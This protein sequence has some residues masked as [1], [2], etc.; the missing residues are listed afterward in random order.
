MDNAIGFSNTYRLDTDLSFGQRYP[1]FEQLATEVYVA[2]CFLL[3]A[4][5]SL[6]LPQI[7]LFN[8]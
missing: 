5:W 1:T 7:D 6:E 2:L 3:H 8:Q 4:G